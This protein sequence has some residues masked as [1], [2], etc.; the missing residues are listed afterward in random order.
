MLLINFLV[1]LEFI[2]MNDI[3]IKLNILF[4]WLKYNVASSLSH[5]GFGISEILRNTMEQNLG[6]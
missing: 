3:I 6:E 4:I 2:K 1:C 5:N